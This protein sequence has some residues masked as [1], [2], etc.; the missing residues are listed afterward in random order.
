MKDIKEITETYSRMLWID[1]GKPI[2]E[3]GVPP[4]KIVDGEIK[5]DY[6]VNENHSISYLVDGVP[7]VMDGKIV[8]PENVVTEWLRIRNYHALEWLKI[9]LKNYGH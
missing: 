6:E 2:N 1:T 5:F 8:N 9:Q 7:D 3:Q 4:Y